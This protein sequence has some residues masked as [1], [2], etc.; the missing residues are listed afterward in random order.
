MLSIKRKA[1]ILVLGG[2]LAG[3]TMGADSCEEATKDLEDVS[4]QNDADYRAD[5][6]RIK[7]GMSASEVR[8]I[9]GKPRDKQIMRSEFGRSEFWYY[10]SWQISIEDGTVTGKNR[11]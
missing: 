4:G 1:L 5:M 6:K 2:L 3:A 9:A 7:L 8:A 11:Y 10:G